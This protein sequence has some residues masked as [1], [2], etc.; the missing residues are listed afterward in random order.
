[1][2]LG[3]TT[4]G[5][6]ACVPENLVGNAQLPPNV[7][8]PNAT[9][10]PQGALESYGGA[11]YAFRTAVG[12]NT[13]SYVPVS[14]LLTDELRSGNVGA[15]SGQ[16]TDGMLLDSRFLPE[17]GG[18]GTDVA[19]LTPISSVYGLL[20]KVRGQ[21]HEA[22]GELVT[23]NPSAPLALRGHLYAIEGYTDI[24]LADLFCSGI[25]LSTLNFRGDYT[26]A[27]GSTTEEVY[28]QAIVYFDSALTL[29]GDSTR[30][31]NM[32]RVGKGRALLALARYADAATAV[33]PVPDGYQYNFVF[34]QT[35]SA[36]PNG[37]LT[38]VSFVYTD[39]TNALTYGLAL[40]MVDREGENGLPY[41]TSGDPRS[42]WVSDGTN[43]GGFPLSAPAKYPAAGDG[44]MTLAS[45]VEARLIQA[46]AALEVGDGSWLTTLNT[47]RTDGTFTTQPDPSNPSQ[48][49]TIW[50]AGT[51]GM[52]G[53]K[54]LTDPGTADARVTMLFDERAYW[55][56]LTGHRQ[57][58]LRRLIRQYGRTEQQVYPVGVY[59]GAYNTYGTAVTA[60]IPGD[61]RINNP[62]FHGC[63]GRQA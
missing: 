39:F 48:T 17:Y 20:Q 35:V 18:S 51:G 49:D 50:N 37:V 32:A 58:D 6:A 27:P 42:A 16:I 34:D 55:L 25:P 15:S 22:R 24:M 13:Y 10:T 61:E 11:V 26:V 40:T 38:N 53:L 4:V 21:T 46:E 44:F 59:Q 36:G 7:A 45:G 56:F 2:A 12:G 33:S 57:G 62:L 30:L 5:L 14:G 19:T 29:V 31:L 60:P 28:Q 54:P 63:R 23:Y 3:L 9:H 43:Q 52:P 41:V 1:M 8:D 47:L